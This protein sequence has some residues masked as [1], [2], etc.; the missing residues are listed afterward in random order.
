[1]STGPFLVSYSLTPAVQLLATTFKPLCNRRLSLNDY[2]YGQLLDQDSV[3]HL[4]KCVRLD[5]FSHQ[6]ADSPTRVSGSSCQYH[7]QIIYQISMPSIMCN[8]S[9]LIY[10]HNVIRHPIII[11][12]NHVHTICMTL[13][14]VDT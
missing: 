8:Y 9:V 1:M 7:L 6:C 2:P 10:V 14:L 12:Y 3:S 13:Q 11:K 4:P 5:S